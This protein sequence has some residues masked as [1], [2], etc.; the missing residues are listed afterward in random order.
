MDAGISLAIN[1]LDIITTSCNLKGWP[2]FMLELHC[3]C[4]C[5]VYGYPQL[6]KVGGF[7]S[8]YFTSP[9]GSLHLGILSNALTSTNRTWLV[10]WYSCVVS[11][12]CL[13]GLT[14]I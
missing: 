2:E 7:A 8:L 4:K 9:L 12:V 6:F 10:G 13:T 3:P 14:L 1:L 5:T 11:L